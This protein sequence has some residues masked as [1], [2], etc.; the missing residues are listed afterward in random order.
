MAKN[1]FSEYEKILKIFVDPGKGCFRNF[2]LFFAIC[3]KSQGVELKRTPDSDSARK[4]TIG[5]SG[6]NTDHFFLCPG[7]LIVL[8]QINRQLNPILTNV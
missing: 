7:I 4:N 8:S 3:S 6:Q 5:G 2:Q 1:H